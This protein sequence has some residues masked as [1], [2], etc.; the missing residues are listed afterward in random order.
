[1]PAMIRQGELISEISGLLPADVDGEW[2]S[3]TFTPRLVSM[4]S[5]EDLVVRR[6]DGSEDGA[7]SPDAVYDLLKELRAVMYRPDAGT[8]LS[9]TWVIEND[10]TNLTSDVSFNYTDEPTWYSQV[11]PGLYGL[12][13]EKYPRRHDAIPEWMNAKLAEARARAS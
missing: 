13:L 10:G 5:E 7:L 2:V 9:A 1:M 3:L 11:D 6:P 4:Y 8:W 12:D